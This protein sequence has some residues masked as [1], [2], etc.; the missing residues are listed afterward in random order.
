MLDV[1]LNHV[2][3]ILYLIHVGFEKNIF[4][5]S[6]PAAESTRL[7]TTHFGKADMD[8]KKN[9]NSITYEA[10]QKKKEIEPWVPIEYYG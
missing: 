9:P 7:V 2:T 5:I 3:K 8:R 6:D 1:Y 4:L 10:L